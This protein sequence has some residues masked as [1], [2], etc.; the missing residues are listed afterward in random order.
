MKRF[1]AKY[2]KVG[3]SGRFGW[4]KRVRISDEVDVN[5]AI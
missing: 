2:S 3:K 4:R 1:N 5:K